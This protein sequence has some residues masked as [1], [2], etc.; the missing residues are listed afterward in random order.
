MRKIL[1]TIHFISKAFIL[2]FTRV[3]LKL[4]VVYDVE[5]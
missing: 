5:K 2:N 1:L 3:I 4:H